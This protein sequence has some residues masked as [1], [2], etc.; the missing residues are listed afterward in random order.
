MINPEDQIPFDDHESA[1]KEGQLSQEDIHSNGLEEE[2]TSRIREADAD[3]DALRQAYSA[4]E[5]AY[6]LEKEPGTDYRVRRK[7]KNEGSR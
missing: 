3:P 6:L 5:S 4:S 7:V 1:D 2:R